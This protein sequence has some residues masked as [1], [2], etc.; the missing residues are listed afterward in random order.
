M[1]RRGGGGGRKGWDWGGREGG[2][3]RPAQREAQ[4]RRGRPLSVGAA[5][6]STRSAAGVAV[7]KN[8]AHHPS[9]GVR[10][11]SFACAAAA[12]TEPPNSGY[13]KKQTL[14]LEGGGGGGEEGGGGKWAGGRWQERRRGSCCVFTRHPPLPDVHPTQT[15][16]GG[17]M[18]REGNHEDHQQN[19]NGGGRAGGWEGGGPIRRGNCKK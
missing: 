19:K 9:V 15:P 17:E 7:S 6:R 12:Q 10:V 18:A 1:G 13:T 11:P 4:A 16:S 5:D 3:N 2:T 8:E 14:L